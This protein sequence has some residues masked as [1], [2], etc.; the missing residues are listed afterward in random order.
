MIGGVLAFLRKRLDAYLKA[1]LTLPDE[2]VADKVVFLD[3]D[4]MDPLT[5]Q[6]GAVSELLVNV[7]E[8]RLLRGADPYVDVQDDGKPLRVSPNLRLGLHILFVARFKQ[9]DVGWDHLAKIVDYLRMH[10]G[11]EQEDSAD[12]PVGVER[13]TVELISQSFAEQNEVWSALRAAY[14]PSLLYRV[15]LVIIR[16]AKPATAEQVTQPVVV[17]VRR[18]P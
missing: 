7:E 15:R 6:E 14:H 9:Y 4:K 16:D 18:M 10:R 11:F 3:G 5:F 1:E 17:R 8:E 13:L 12:L 2:P